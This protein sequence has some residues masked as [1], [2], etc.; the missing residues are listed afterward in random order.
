MALGQHKRAI[1]VF[2]TRQDIE[3][4][5]EELRTAGFPMSE[6][7]VIARDADRDDEIAGVEVQDHIGNEAGR[8]AAAGAIAGGAT[9]GI[10]GFI[11][12][13]SAL[14]VP[15]I[16]PILT[17]GALASVIGDALIGSA[18]GAAAGGLVGALTGLGVPEERAEVYN[19]RL[20]RG[21]YLLLVE[22][23]DDDI[24]IANSI[25]NRRG[26]Q[27]W[28]IYDAPRANTAATG[29]ITPE[30]TSTGQYSRSGEMASTSSIPTRTTPADYYPSAN[31][32]ATY[33]RENKRAVGV[34]SRS[35]DME[36]ALMALSNAGFPMDNVSVI[37]KDA[38]WQNDDIEMLGR[39]G[40]KAN[41]GIATGAVAGGALGGVA[42]LLIGLSALAIPGIGPLLFAGAEATAIA[43]TLAGGAMGTA[44]GS[45]IGGLIGVGIPEDRAKYYSDRVSLDQ[46]LVMVT[47][48]D[49]Q[50]HRA[51]SILRERGIQDWGVYDQK[52]L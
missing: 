42:G 13:L 30:G 15:G 43:T 16:G 25:L 50:I 49:A 48:S 20:K 14:S 26:I 28:G 36:D 45:L 39:L 19:E 24:A 44:A 5:L 34:F 40:N 37:A 27:E 1:G 46:Y 47:G 51:E 12:A 52:S 4:A 9:G 7:S 41:K 33:S 35:Q 10:V 18:V 21:D 38:S 29:A 22:G 17:G 11:G 6:V 32:P 23:S 3:H 2:S 8:G 31:A